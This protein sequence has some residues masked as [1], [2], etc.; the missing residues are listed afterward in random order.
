MGSA[1]SGAST[2]K[3][4]KGGKV[5]PEEGG[6]DERDKALGDTMDLLEN[7]NKPNLPKSD[8]FKLDSSKPQ[9]MLHIKVLPST[10]PPPAPAPASP[11]DP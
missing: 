9:S 5:S 6:S 1:R 10:T 7:M 8:S 4:G 2:K 3:A 11:D